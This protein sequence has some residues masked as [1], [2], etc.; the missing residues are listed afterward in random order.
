MSSFII[1]VIL[2]IIL[3]LIGTGILA[4]WKKYKY[5]NIMKGE[6]TK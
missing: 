2:A 3:W 4:L 6:N 1:G 5:R